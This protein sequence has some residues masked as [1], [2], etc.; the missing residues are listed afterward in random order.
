MK[1]GIQIERKVTKMWISRFLL[2]F[3]NVGLVVLFMFLNSFWTTV[4]CVLVFFCIK[5]INAMRT[6]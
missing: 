5:D 2:D 6:V 1:V 4:M 3:L